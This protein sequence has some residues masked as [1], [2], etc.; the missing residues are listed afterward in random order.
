MRNF[1]DNNSRL[2]RWSVKLSDLDFVVEQRAGPKIRHA[3]ALRRYV[4][5][6][7][8][9]NTLH[10]ESILREQDRDNL[11]IERNPG[12]ISRKC[13]FFRDNE[14]VIYKRHPRGKHQIGI[15][16]TLFQTVIKENHDPFYVAD[17]GIKRTY[18][19]ISLNY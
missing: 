16:R 3:D 18:D 5:A 11:Y 7:T 1:A 19:L 8:L 10:K 17:P 15:L 14:G 13:V 9:A 4:D 12:T 2:L 6:V